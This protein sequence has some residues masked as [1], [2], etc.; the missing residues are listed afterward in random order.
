MININNKINYNQVKS[1]NSINKN[2]DNVMNKITSYFEILN[3]NNEQK[4]L[5]NTPTYKITNDKI[6]IEI[7]YYSTSKTVINKQNFLDLN[8]IISKEVDKE[9]NIIINRIHYPYINSLIFAKYLSH[10]SNYCNYT[11][12]QDYINSNIKIVKNS[13]PAS[14]LGIKVTISGRIPTQRVIP[15][16]TIKTIIYGTFKGNHNIIIDYNKFTT[17]NHLGTFTFKVWIC[18]HI[19]LKKKK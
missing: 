18:Q 6:N 13:L 12:Y 8:K 10:N 15:R 1:F 16:K 11:K 2:Y 14:I 4:I 17:S 5:I 19:K 3:N 9:I 7:I